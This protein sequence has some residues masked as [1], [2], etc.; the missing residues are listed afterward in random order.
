MKKIS[1]GSILGTR[2]QKWAT[3]YHNRAMGC[4]KVIKKVGSLSI[5]DGEGHELD[6]GC[7]K[8]ATRCDT[9]IKKLARKVFSGQDVVNL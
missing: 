2:Y 9:Y 8:L 5:L 3:G 6:T 7:H 1:S 4:H